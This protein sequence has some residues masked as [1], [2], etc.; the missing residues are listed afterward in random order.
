MEDTLK[1]TQNDDGSFV[2]DWDPEDPKW[3]WLN[4]LTSEEVQ[5]IVQQAIEDFTDDC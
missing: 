3:K 1:I 5:S 2:M 4:E